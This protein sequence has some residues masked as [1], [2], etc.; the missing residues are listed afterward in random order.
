MI[1]LPQLPECWDYSC[2]SLHLVNV[3]LEYT[4]SY[5]LKFWKEDGKKPQRSMKEK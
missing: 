2:V 1:L 5:F 3:I 4:K